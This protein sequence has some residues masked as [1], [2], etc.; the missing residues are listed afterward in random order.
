VKPKRKLL[1]ELVDKTKSSRGGMVIT[2]FKSNITGSRGAKLKNSIAFHLEI[3]SLMKE[4]GR[5]STK[6]K[7]LKGE[8]SP[9]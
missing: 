5:G 3:Q 7:F 1:N 8:G 2:K 6:G 9:K 4:V